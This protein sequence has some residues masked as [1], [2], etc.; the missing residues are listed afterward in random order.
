MSLAM[1]L[2]SAEVGRDYDSLVS[3]TGDQA[4]LVIQPPAGWALSS[5]S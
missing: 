3:E 4:Q 5:S 2:P 1:A